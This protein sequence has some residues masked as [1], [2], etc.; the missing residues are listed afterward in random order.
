MKS[1]N[2]KLKTAPSQS[3]VEGLVRP[4]RLTYMSI[5]FMGVFG[6][7]I[8]YAGNFVAAIFAIVILVQEYCEVTTRELI[9]SQHEYIKTLEDALEGWVA[10]LR[11]A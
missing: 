7:W 4:S 9:N 6:I 8:A 2:E 3:A 5:I 1:N 11:K 10:K